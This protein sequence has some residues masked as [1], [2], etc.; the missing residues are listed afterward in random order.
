MADHE[1]IDV[2]IHLTN[3]AARAF[4]FSASSYLLDVSLE[5]KKSP[6]VYVFFFLAP[7]SNGANRVVVVFI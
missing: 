3:G 6:P 1:Y 2:F 7:K 4:D 5:E